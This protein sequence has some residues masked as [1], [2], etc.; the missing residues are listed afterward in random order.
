M[1]LDETAPM[2][3]TSFAFPLFH[4]QRNNGKNVAANDPAR[5]EC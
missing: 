1:M 3:P 4:N 5:I 2:R